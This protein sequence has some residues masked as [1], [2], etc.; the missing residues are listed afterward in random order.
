M[1]YLF[2]TLIIESFSIE[3]EWN[4]S[5]FI[6]FV[7]LVSKKISIFIISESVISKDA[8]FLKY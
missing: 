3:N 4:K 1:N 6:E 7:F 2:V 5:Q 8:N